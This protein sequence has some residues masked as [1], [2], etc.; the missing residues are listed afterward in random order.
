VSDL[1]PADEIYLYQLG[2]VAILLMN[3]RCTC[4]RI[5]CNRATINSIQVRARILAW[6]NE[7]SC[8]GGYVCTRGIHV[9]VDPLFY[10]LHMRT[11]FSIQGWNIHE[12]PRVNT[13]AGLK[14]LHSMRQIENH[15]VKLDSPRNQL[16]GL[17]PESMLK[18]I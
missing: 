5:L 7:F 1:R 17:G 4:M 2:N 11:T 14:S 15:I 10:W 3:R 6:R 13:S 9:S 16:C 12:I 8:L 18:L